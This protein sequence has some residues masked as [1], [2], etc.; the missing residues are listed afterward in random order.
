MC[1]I[2]WDC[3]ICLPFGIWRYMAADGSWE[4]GNVY[5]ILLD[6]LG[7][8]PVTIGGFILRTCIF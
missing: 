8:F 2:C 4:S 3:V 6:G 1:K 7:T 5:K